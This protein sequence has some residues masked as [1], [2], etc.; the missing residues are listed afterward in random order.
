MTLAVA[1]VDIIGE[2][3]T[4]LTNP[5]GMTHLSRGLLLTGDGLDGS[6]GA[7]LRAAG[8]LGA[9]VSTLIGELGLHEAVETGGRTKHAIG[10][11]RHTQL[12]GRAVLGKVLGSECTGRQD[13]CL[14]LGYLLVEYLG[15]SAIDLL[16]LGLEGSSSSHGSC[17]GEEGAA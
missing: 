13:G 11:S 10:A 9:A 3:D 5:Y 2:Y 8:A 12:A 15:Q 7:H 1:A 14:T 6:C 17:G 4:V 16:L